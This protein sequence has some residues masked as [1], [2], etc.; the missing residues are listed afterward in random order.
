VQRLTGYDLLAVL[1]DHLERQLETGARPPVADA[2]GN[3]AAGT[4]YAGAEGAPVAFA[5]RATDPDAGDVLAYAWDFGDGATA[6]GAAPAHAYRDDGEY[7]ARLVVTD[8]WGLT[9]TA[10]VP[11][12]VANVGPA[13]GAFAGAT[14]LVGERYAAAGTFADPGADT[15][16]ASVDYGDGAAGPLALDGR[17]FALA[18]AYTAAGT[19]TVTVT[20]RDDDGGAGT[21]TATVVVQSSAQGIANLREMVRALAAARSITA[22]QAAALTATLDAAALQLARGETGSAAGTL[23]SFRA[24]VADFSA[25]GRLPAADA[26]R[27]DAYARRVVRSVGA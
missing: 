15:W 17:A 12:R 13:V 27:L 2:G 25:A 18:H 7:T 24:Q 26:A 16:T 14:L 9:D 21:G 6:T 4:A 3:D 23:E 8:R 5:G 10:R 1:P 19:R 11:V 20:V 22:G